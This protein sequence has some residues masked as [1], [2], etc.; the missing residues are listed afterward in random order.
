MQILCNR[1]QK[2]YNSMKTKGPVGRNVESRK[3]YWKGSEENRIMEHR[4]LVPRPLQTLCHLLTFCRGLL[5]VLSEL[6]KALFISYQHLVLQTLKLLQILVLFVTN[7]LFVQDPGFH[8]ATLTSSS[9][10]PVCNILV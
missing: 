5:L 8:R 2:V 1:L 6:L 4:H 7:W 9:I 10:S 3:K